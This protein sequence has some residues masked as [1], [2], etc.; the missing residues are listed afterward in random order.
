MEPHEKSNTG[1]AS[2]LQLREKVRTAQVLASSVE[3]L[4][5]DSKFT[6]RMCVVVQNGRILKCGYE[7]GYF[8][9]RQD[10]RLI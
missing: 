5:R 3:R 10:E 1:E 8:S 4:L 7:E 2:F 9:R 6:G